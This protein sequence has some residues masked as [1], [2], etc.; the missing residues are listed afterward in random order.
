MYVNTNVLNIT[1]VV[2]YGLP[3]YT[4]MHFSDKIYTYRG[5]YLYNIVKKKQD[6]YIR[7]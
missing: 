2:S 6:I 5:I 4:C 1:I 3:S 7:L